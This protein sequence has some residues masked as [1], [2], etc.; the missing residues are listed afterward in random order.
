M[1]PTKVDNE[2]IAPST[3]TKG[4]PCRINL[5][6]QSQNQGQTFSVAATVAE[7]RVSVGQPS[8]VVLNVA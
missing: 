8:W 1:W 6:L 5:H 3:H 4:K 2:D 7:R